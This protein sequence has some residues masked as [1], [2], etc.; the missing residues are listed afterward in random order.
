MALGDASAL[1]CHGKR[2]NI[3]F[4]IQRNSVWRGKLRY[5]RAHF[6][7]AVVA[8]DAI[9]AEEYIERF[10][11]LMRYAVDCDI[12]NG[13][14]VGIVYSSAAK[15]RILHEC[16]AFHA[17]GHRQVNYPRRLYKFLCSR[18]R[19]MVHDARRGKS[20]LPCHIYRLCRRIRRERI[21]CM[22][23]VVYKACLFG[24]GIAP[25]ILRA[26]SLA[27]ASSLFSTFGELSSFQVPL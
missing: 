17:D 14:L 10:D 19:I 9:V 20:A 13:F 16:A 12:C 15:L 23:M 4:K 27:R 22:Y 3:V 7:V 18:E 11:I 8:L 26:R 2:Q 5:A 6:P 24:S 21:R 1:M 25:V